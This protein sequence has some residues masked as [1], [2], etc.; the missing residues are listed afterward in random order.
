[1]RRRRRQRRKRRTSSIAVCAHSARMPEPRTFVYVPTSRQCS[2]RTRAAHRAP[3]ARTGHQE[4]LAETQAERE[5]LDRELDIAERTSELEARNRWAQQLEY[6]PED[7]AG[8]ASS[9]LQDEAAPNI[10]SRPSRQ[11]Y[12][13]SCEDQELARTDR[14][15]ARNRS[16]LNA[17]AAEMRRNWRSASSCSTPR[18]PRWKN[19]PRGRSASSSSAQQLRKTADA[20]A[21]PAG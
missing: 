4:R 21:H 3:R 5:A 7:A 12:E 15:G 13:A 8:S 2:A 11:S 16:R 18:R 1:M 6:G 17:R 19:A 20:F 14:V 9:Q 10:G